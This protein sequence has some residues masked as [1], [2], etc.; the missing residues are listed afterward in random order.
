MTTKMSCTKNALWVGT[1]SSGDVQFIQHIESM[2]WTVTVKSDTSSQTSDANGKDAVFISST[3]NSGSVGTKFRDV[4]IPVITWESHLADDMAL[5]TGYGTGYTNKEITLY[6][7][8]FWNS[9]GNLKIIDSDHGFRGIWNL[10]SGMT[11]EAVLRND[12]GR[13][14]LAWCNPGDQ[15][16]GRTAA[17]KRVY[18]G[19]ED[20][21]FPYLKNEGKELITNIVNWMHSCEVQ[22][23]LPGRTPPIPVTPKARRDRSVLPLQALGRGRGILQKIV[24]SGRMRPPKKPAGRGRSIVQRSRRKPDIVRAS[25]QKVRFRP[26][27]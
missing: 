25:R 14:F 22:E 26:T 7:T 8:T 18:I 1:G 13:T 20:N 19:L 16:I 21:T 11:Q 23:P 4:S 6:G 5:C 2:G 15:L 24:R 17:G 3:V 10:A 12:T 27:Q 9:T